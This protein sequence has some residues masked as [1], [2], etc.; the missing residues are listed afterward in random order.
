VVSGGLENKLR[1]ILGPKGEEVL[2]G[3]RKLYNEFHNPCCFPNIIK[4]ITSRKMR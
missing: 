3:W 2:G 1:R 4:V